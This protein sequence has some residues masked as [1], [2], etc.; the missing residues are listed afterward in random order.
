[1]NSDLPAPRTV[2]PRDDRYQANLAAYFAYTAA[3]G[4]SFG[5]FAATW[6][7]YL[8]RQRGLTLANAALVD[9]T[10]FVVAAVAEIPT[11]V[12]ADRH[13]RTVS[14][15]IGTAL[16]GLGALAWVSAPT[17][18]LII[19]SYTGLAVGF[20]FVSGA[21]D[22][23]LY[24]TV[25][26]AG[27]SSDYRRLTG[28]AA[29]TMLVTLAAGSALSGLLASIWLPLPFVCAAAGHLVAFVAIA[30]MN[31]PSHPTAQ[32]DAT[33]R[34]HPVL[35]RSLL[36]DALRLVRREPRVRWPVLYIAAI[37]LAGLILETLLV[38]PQA[39]QLGIPIAGLGLI[40]MGLQLAGTVGGLSADRLSRRLG[41]RAVLVGVPIVIVASLVG[42]AATQVRPALGYIGLVSLSTATLRPIILHRIQANVT[43][44]TRATVLSV[45][46]L[47]GTLGAAIAQP[48]L[49]R[50]ADRN[51]LPAAYI[52]LG[53]IIALATVG[54]V[55]PLLTVIGQPSGQQSE[56][57][58]P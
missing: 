57:F 39:I 13:G 31:E 32:P 37:P 53:A 58:A 1:V 15:K 40:V 4:V 21:D 9:V 29:A 22:A 41:E 42:L 18:P 7:I 43:D 36:R 35:A 8:Q 34:E 12:V 49:G 24:E 55:R 5:L 16:M 38:Q 30:T 14:L 52:V 51:G 45:A 48:V 11:G 47:L 20:T 54:L 56:A 44:S 17:L 50:I 6:V 46:S 33:E 2:R 3:K 23:L 28:R 19:A 27:H 25:E 26:H 10:F